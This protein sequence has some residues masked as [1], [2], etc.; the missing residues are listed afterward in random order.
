MRSVTLEQ[1]DNR[2]RYTKIKN[3]KSIK[4]PYEALK[5]FKKNTC[6]DIKALRAKDVSQAMTVFMDIMK[7]PV[8]Y[9]L[10][11][12]GTQK[13]G[14]I[15]G[16]NMPGDFLGI[17]MDN[18][19]Y[20][21]G[22][23]L[24]L[25]VLHVVLK[26]SGRS[27]RAEF[28]LFRDYRLLRHSKGK[29]LKAKFKGLKN[30]GKRILMKGVTAKSVGTQY[31]LHFF[32]GVSLGVLFLGLF[33]M[34]SDVDAFSRCMEEAGYIRGG[35]KDLAYI[36]TFAFIIPFI[37]EL[38]FHAHNMTVLR[39]DV[40]VYTASIIVTVLYMLFHTG[41][42][43][44]LLF[45]PVMLLISFVFDRTQNTRN[46]A[47]YVA[48][49]SSKSMFT[50]SVSRDKIISIKDRAGKG[51]KLKFTGKNAN[52]ALNLEETKGVE[53]DGNI[54][55]ETNLC[56]AVNDLS[57]RKDLNKEYNIT[58]FRSER[59]ETAKPDITYSL[60][61]NVGFHLMLGAGW[62]YIR[63]RGAAVGGIFS[64]QALM[65]MV[66]VSALIL[67]KFVKKQHLFETE[68]KAG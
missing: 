65:F 56:E 53:I 41:K 64:R 22:N 29:S 25:L 20:L 19:L 39:K 44:S 57:G 52:R 5:R 11:I 54:E 59:P 35:S 42:T 63:S 51:R 30:K 4:P 18:I 14:M 32:A 43:F 46:I 24:F 38:I 26:A 13:L 16:Q 55:M 37:E 15:M 36:I 34:L 48:G 45:I 31:F 17:G 23:L 47:D 21:S 2:D 12:W 62:I 28:S 7:Y 60:L 40:S 68:E 66:I 1:F 49:R 8:I 67:Y 10:C 61:M 50:G 33:L 3:I 27:L 6:D 58:D 9:L